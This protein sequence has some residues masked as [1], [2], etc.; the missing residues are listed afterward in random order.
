MFLACLS[1]SPSS[2]IFKNLTIYAVIMWCAC[3]FSS[4]FCCYLLMLAA[5]VP[6]KIVTLNPRCICL[7]HVSKDYYFIVFQSYGGEMHH[8]CWAWILCTLF[9]HIGFLVHDQPYKLW[10]TCDYWMAVPERLWLWSKFVLKVWNF[11]CWTHWVISAQTVKLSNAR[12]AGASA[13][14]PPTG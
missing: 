1:P 3:Y 7:V 8:L 12:I 2:F 11:F 9:L 4:L 13:R 14:L 5:R 6:G 10:G